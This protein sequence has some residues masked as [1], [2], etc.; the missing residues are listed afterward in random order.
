[1]WL[2]RRPEAPD[3]GPQ[4]EAGGNLSG[5]P[6][7]YHRVPPPEIRGPGVPQSRLGPLGVPLFSV[8]FSLFF[9][10]FLNVFFLSYSFFFREGWGGGLVGVFPQVETQI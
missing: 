9:D 2:P 1:M 4:W 6:G 10:V 5:A 7:G 3:R 8:L